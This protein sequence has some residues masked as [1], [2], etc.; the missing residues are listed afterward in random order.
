[1]TLEP[2][3]P[4]FSATRIAE[5]LAV[6]PAVPLTPTAEQRTV[7]EHPLGGSALVVAGA[8]SG[9]TETM[10]NR[11]VWLVANGLVSP[12]QVLGLTFT[13]KAAGELRERISLRLALFVSRLQDQAEREQLSEI[14]AAH[15]ARLTEL[16]AD[17]LE[18]PEVSTYNA[19]A[20]GVLQEFGIAAGVAPGAVIIDEATAWR[21]ARE[22]ALQSTDSALVQSEL[23]LPQIVNH[24]LNLDHAVADNLTSF[25]RVDQIVS[26]FAR[27]LELPYSEKELTGERSG[28]V[29]APVRDAVAALKETPLITRLAREFAE[30]KQRRGVLEFSDQLALATRAIERSRDAISILRQRHRV[31]LLD[32]VQDTSVGQTRFLSR[33][34]AG[35]SVMAVG[36]PHQS[37]Y[38]WRG[39]SAEGLQSF[40]ADFRGRGETATPPATLTLSTSWRNPGRVLDVANVIA[41]PSRTR[42]PWL[43]QSSH[44]GR[45][46]SR[47]ASNGYSPRPCMKNDTPWQ[48]G[49]VMPGKRTS[50]ATANCR[51][52]P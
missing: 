4:V 27:V 12:D 48:P 34:F 49:C 28:K 31:I 19:F 13:R 41:A 35:R 30:E 7:I 24:V 37:I 46:R 3:S 20:A 40:H 17:G 36:D 39:A 2:Q 5:I 38:G 8:G 52:Q 50:R 16:L 22:T 21:I 33:I 11:V 51:V 32:E 23:R 1:M 6:P 18:L 42:R 43:C 25:D 14:E 44:P 10:A 15:A 9:K 29:Y 45:A 47:A 26:E